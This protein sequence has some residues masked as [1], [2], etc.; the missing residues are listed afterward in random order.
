MLIAE[1]FFLSDTHKPAHRHTDTDGTD[2]SARASAV[3]GIG[4]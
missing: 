2:Q 1:A 4:N 3:A